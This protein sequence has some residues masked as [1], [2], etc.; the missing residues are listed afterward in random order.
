MAIIHP[1]DASHPEP[2]A[3]ENRRKAFEL[4]D[5]WAKQISTL[6]TG[7]LILSAT[8]IKDILGSQPT[9]WAASLYVAWALLLFTT[10]LGLV[11]QGSLTSELSRRDGRLNVNS[12]TISKAAFAQFASFFLGLVAFAVFAGRNL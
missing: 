11:V 5:G 12:G 6:A 4:A 10:V 8:F 2:E 9:H 3:I 1:T 7:A